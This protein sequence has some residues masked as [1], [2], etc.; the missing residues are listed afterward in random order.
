MVRADQAS[1]RRRIAAT[2]GQ[3]D[4]FATYRMLAHDRA[5]FITVPARAQQYIVGNADL[6]DIVE[7]RGQSDLRAGF[8]I[9]VAM[10]GKVLRKQ[11]HAVAVVAGIG[12]TH[13]QRHR[14]GV[15]QAGLRVQ[16]VGRYG[17]GHRNWRR[18][19]AAQET[20]RP[21]RAGRGGA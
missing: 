5:L 20:E 4:M 18:G 15:D 8:L 3:E 2:G 6:A 9:Q 17:Q 19:K 13:L 12:I 16:E 10:Q 11:A 21:A 14:Q 1:D 7:A